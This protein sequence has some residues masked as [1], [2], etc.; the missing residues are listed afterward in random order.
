VSS[1]APRIVIVTRRTELEH[2]MAQHATRGQAEFFLKSRGQTIDV[3]IARD[4]LQSITIQKARQF[5][6]DDWSIAA[7]NRRDL[8]RFLFAPNDIVIPIGQDGLVANLAKYL[9]GQPVI[10]I[11][12]DP[13][14]SE[15]VLTPFAVDALPKILKAIQHDDVFL[16]RRTM[17]EARL[18]D[19]QTLL[20]LNEVFLGHKS[21]Q[22]A[23]YLIAHEQ[24]EEYQSSSGIIVA[25]G[26]GITGW[27]KSILLSTHRDISLHPNDRQAV[28]FAREPW[29]S[30]TSGANLSFGAISNSDHLNVTSRMNSDGVIFADGIEQDFLKFNWGTKVSIGVSENTLNLVSDV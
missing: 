25:T 17:V 22:S 29:P 13:K 4:E 19:G 10:G 28:F 23:K 14:Q 26:T 9:T 2:L 30:R 12:P 3:L 7:V 8:D 27:A 5:I 15:G 20:A 24:T 1:L 18:D 21:H 11:T 6:P 16:Q